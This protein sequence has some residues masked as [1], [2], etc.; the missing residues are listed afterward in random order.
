M[1]VLHRKRSFPKFRNLMP[2][3]NKF[4]LSKPYFCTWHSSLVDIVESFV[5]KNWFIHHRNHVLYLVYHVAMLLPRLT[6]FC[7]FLTGSY[8]KKKQKK[9]TPWNLMFTTWTGEVNFYENIIWQL[10]DRYYKCFSS[11]CIYWID[12]ISYYISWLVVTAF[13]PKKKLLKYKTVM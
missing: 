1:K 10:F 3:K 6:G 4:K 8:Y 7:W 2:L 13:F 5:E 11:Q 9:T 12:L